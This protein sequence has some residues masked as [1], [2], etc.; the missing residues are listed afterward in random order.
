MEQL[1]K[2][3][4][5]MYR[6]FLFHLTWKRRLVSGSMGKNNPLWRGKRSGNDISKI[7]LISGLKYF[8]ILLLFLCSH[9]VFYVSYIFITLLYFSRFA[10]LLHLSSLVSFYVFFKSRLSILNH[11]KVIYMTCNIV[12]YLEALLLCWEMAVEVSYLL[13]RPSLNHK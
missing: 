13:L 9:F 10:I 5:F 1:I 8:G 7:H 2:I 6:L 11:Q 3:F 12:L 4:L